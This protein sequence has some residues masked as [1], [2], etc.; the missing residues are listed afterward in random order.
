MSGDLHFGKTRRNLAKLLI[1]MMILLA[2]ESK[3]PSGFRCCRWEQDKTAIRVECESWENVFAVL[4]SEKFRGYTKEQLPSL[5]RLPKEFLPILRVLKRMDLCEFN[6]KALKQRGSKS[7]G[8]AFTLINIPSQSVQ[9]CIDELTNIF[10]TYKPPKKEE[11]TPGPLPVA[12]VVTTQIAGRPDL[13]PY[14]STVRRSLARKFVGP[15]PYPRP[16][17][18]KT[19]RATIQQVSLCGCNG[20]SR[21][22]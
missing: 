3:T 14:F 13:I 21:K 12:S 8:I 1:Q 20:R 17:S 6:E 2:N 5:D 15:H 4:Q 7:G 18:P 19:D 9:R 10:K 16:A 11:S 22:D